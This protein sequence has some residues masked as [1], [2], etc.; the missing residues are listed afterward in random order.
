MLIDRFPST[1][2]LKDYHGP[3]GIMVDGRD[4]V[5]PEKFG[6]RLFDSY[7]GPKRLWRFPDSGHIAIEEPPRFWSEVLDFWRTNKPEQVRY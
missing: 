6:I 2:Y 1:D 3:V 4:E 7:T 5:V